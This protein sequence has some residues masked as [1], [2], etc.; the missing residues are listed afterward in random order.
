MSSALYTASRLRV[1]GQCKRAEFYRYTLGIRTPSGPAAD[2]G[3]HTHSA[4]EAW[5]CAWK[6]EP[7]GS[8]RLS[9]AFAAIDAL[10]C[11]DVTR[12]KLRALIAAYH[13]RWGAEDWQVIAVEVEFRYWLGDA[14]L[15]G[16]ID[17]IIR[18]RSTG[19]Y[20]LV[21]H[22]TSTQDTSPGSPYWAKL[23]VDT[24]ISI[25][26]DGA[27]FGLDIDVSGCVYDVLKRPQHE[28]LK[29][30]PDDQIGYTIGKGC[31]SCGGSAK[32]GEIVQGRG[33]TIVNFGSVVEYPPCADCKGTGWKCDKDGVPQAPRPY[34]KNRLT[35]E[36]LE[37]F[38]E[39]VTDEIA[40]KLD[41]YLSRGVIVRLESDLPRMR[42]ELVE[43]IASM[44]ALEA[45]GLHPPTHG[46]CAMGREMCGFW[47]ACSNQTDINDER[48]YPRGNAHPELA[49]VTNNAA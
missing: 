39:R 40:A 32:A 9:A 4:L 17:A 29:A 37:Q 44:R 6:A 38:E 19:R 10:S 16:K 46:A 31:K 8:T 5:Y 36:T 20:L 14:E 30:T 34:A 42:A 24:Q 1:W 22:K 49:A 12:I 21:E 35:D 43:T 25:Y 7:D 2:F 23:A 48:I 11:D 33:H 41:D 13:A 45:A 18:E 3:T 27:A 47:A 28:P 26:M 15:G